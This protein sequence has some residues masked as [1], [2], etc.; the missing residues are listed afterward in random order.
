MRRILA[1]S[2]KTYK[3]NLKQKEGNV[4]LSA[5]QIQKIVI[6]ASRIEDI[7]GKINIFRFTKAQEEAYKPYSADFYM[8]SFATAG[9][10]LEFVTDSK[11]MFLEVDVCKGSSRNYFCHAVYVNGEHIGDL[12]SYE[13]NTG[14]FSKEFDLGEGEKTVAVYFPWTVASKIINLSLDD[15]ATLAPVEKSCKM[16]QFGDSITH[17]YD[18]KA[19]AAS[20]AS[21]VADALDAYAINKGIGGEIFFPTLS[22]LKDDIEPD[23]ITVAYGTNDWSKVN[24]ERFD[25]NSRKFF[26]N[27]SVLYPNAKIF[28][29]APIWRGNYNKEDRKYDFSHTAEHFKAIAKD[30]PNLYVIDCFD[31]VPHDPA[32]FSPDVLHPNDEGFSYYAEN[33]ITALN[34]LI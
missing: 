18:A 24:L 34:K 9:I 15:G 5:E 22:E 16:L 33:L 25:N 32:C 28:A 21:I 12:A 19:P 30:I 26:E 2:R 13:T 31:F 14:V 17:G 4:K 7:D 8:K 29:L 1:H 3:N 20:Y 10:R 6:G 23:Y 27:L 11:K